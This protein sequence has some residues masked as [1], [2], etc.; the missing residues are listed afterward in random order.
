[1]VQQRV[2][3]HTPE[4]AAL[5]TQEALKPIRDSIDQ[6][7]TLTAFGYRPVPLKSSAPY[8]NRKIVW[9]GDSS[10][11]ADT[12]VGLPQEVIYPWLV[13]TYLNASEYVNRHVGGS[14][15][16]DVAMRL[17]DSASPEYYQTPDS[18]A[19][20]H[21]FVGSNDAIFTAW[22]ETGRRSYK[23]SI[24]AIIATLQSPNIH[25]GWTKNGTWDTVDG[26]F[27]DNGKAQ[28]SVTPGSRISHSFTV[29]AGKGVTAMAVGSATGLGTDFTVRID[30]TVIGT[31]NSKNA[32][33]GTDTTPLH[34]VCGPV[35]VSYHSDSWVVGETHTIELEHTGDA[36][37]VLIVNSIHPWGP[38]P[39][40]RISAPM[41]QTAAVY[42]AFNSAHPGSNET[43]DTR[44]RPDLNDLIAFFNNPR[45]KAMDPALLDTLF[46]P[47]ESGLR[48]GDQLHPNIA[49]HARLTRA[50]ID[51]IRGTLTGVVADKYVPAVKSDLAAYARI[52][53]LGPVL[54]SQNTA[55]T[56]VTTSESESRLTGAGVPNYTPPRI[57]ALYVD[58][59][60]KKLYV[61][62][63]TGSP[64]DWI[65]VN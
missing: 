45:I 44:L 16:A 1:M 48:T 39:D 61:A 12:S 10:G 33:L 52:D 17:L 28:R 50:V 43:V 31:Q 35:P 62:V 13:S 26:P 2:R 8:Q 7:Q 59:T 47:D 38:A 56:A 53:D 36:G 24:E 25:S 21:V 32:V 51:T 11:V 41:H 14:I 37:D 55:L 5:D 54:S 42:S 22:S 3:L 6:A 58:T 49:G 64:A 29:G 46:S 23:F 30:G 18:D 19:L 57:A 15:A 20:H 9:H 27:S 65:A 4:E 63:G 34:G 60:N 40:I